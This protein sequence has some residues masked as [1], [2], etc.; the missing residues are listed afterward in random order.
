VLGPNG[1]LKFYFKRPVPRADNDL[2][3]P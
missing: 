1:V 2:W 3:K